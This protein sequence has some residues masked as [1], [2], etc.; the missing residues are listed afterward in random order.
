MILGKSGW[1]EFCIC[2]WLM[3][4][5][6]TMRVRLLAAL[7]LLFA[8]CGGELFEQGAYQEP[9]QEIPQPSLR[10][11]AP[12]AISVGQDMTIFGEGFVDSQIGHS[13]ITFN[14][15][16]QT[17]SGKSNPVELEITPE[18][19]NQ[20]M[21][22]WNFGPN[23]PFTSEEETGVFRGLVR[24]TNIGVDG[25]VKKAPTPVAVELQVLSSILIRQMRPISAGCSV[26]IT[27]SVEDTRFIFELRAIGLKNGTKAAPMRFV[28]TFLKE[29]FRFTGYMADELGMDPEALFPE[30]GPVSVIDTITDGTISVLGTGVPRKVSVV[31]GAVNSGMALGLSELDNLFGLVHLATATVSTPIADYFDA[32]MTVV[33]IDSAG[34]QA[35]RVLPLRVWAPVEVSYDGNATVVRSFDPV[36]VSGCLPG[37][38]IGRDVTYTEHNSETRTRGFKVNAGVQAGFDIKIV[39]LNAEFGVEVNS[40]VASSQSK[41]LVI[42]GLV[43]PKEYAAFYRQTLQLERKADLKSHGPCGNSLYLGEVIVTDWV[44]SPDL[45]KS[46]KCPPLPISNLPK[47]Q[48]YQ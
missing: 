32:Q 10:T 18:V 13:Q 37:G 47:G 48:V 42:S 3:I 23:I 33:A 29:H 6:E 35:S 27:D 22:K 19:V 44:W 45:A 36:P 39:R 4:K 5:G 34:Q 46:K 24:V 8:G 41:D 11:F 1:Y 15:V 2:A 40:E 38:D 28:Y 17:N 30:Q 25:T 43:L 12:S 14:G 9:M 26:G 21:L 16:Y 7:I 31:K 20:G